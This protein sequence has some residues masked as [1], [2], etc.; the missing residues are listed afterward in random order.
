[1]RI[2]MLSVHSS[3]TSLL[4]TNDAGGM[5]VY[6]R[7]LAK[8]LGRQGH[9]VDI[10]TRLTDYNHSETEDLYENVQLIRLRAGQEAYLP[11]LELYDYLDDFFQELDRYKKQKNID[12][13]CIHSHY[14]MSGWVGRLAQNSWKTPQ[15]IIFHTL[16]MVKNIIAGEALEPEI[17][18]DT[19]KDLIETSCRIL[20]FTEREK[21]YLSKCFK[22]S[23]ERIGVVPGGVN[24]ELFR[25]INM[26]FARERV[27]FDDD[28][29]IL[30]YV[31]RFA[32][33]KGLTRLL[34]TMACFKGKKGFR[35]I[36]IGGNG[37]ES[38]EVRHF[39]EISN[40][41]GIQD[42][43]TFAGRVEH[44]ILPY[45]YSA[46]DLLVLPSHYESFGLV[47]LESL[48][49]GTPIIATQVGGMKSILEEGE[50][51]LLVNN[52][53]PS[54]LAKGI[55]TLLCRS[56]EKSPHAI[57]ASIR[58]YRW[59]HIAEKVV[60]EYW[61][62]LKQHQTDSPDDRRQNFIEKRV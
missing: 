41:Y 4:G 51:G 2:A 26:T 62:A 43:V 57:R 1:M 18:I 21:E 50:T 36:I 27:G 35:L 38:T 42:M 56:R 30:L 6:I 60:D 13:D 8:E 37:Q 10:F 44:N 17:R 16:G 47:A 3:P 53:S 29:T 19:E 7:E 24:L 39:K 40:K 33:L 49:C 32:P 59:A 46:A 34:K 11:K 12:Y 61:I 22:V 58:K 28:E 52:F 15:I 9:C 45:Y 31:G 5:S 54:N 14:W 20:A 23:T 25:P 48:A 55:E